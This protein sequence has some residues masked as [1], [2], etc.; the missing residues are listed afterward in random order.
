MATLPD[1]PPQETEALLLEELRRRGLSEAEITQA[2]RKRKRRKGL[3]F[4]AV[5]SR[6]MVDHDINR[7]LNKPA[8][9]AGDLVTVEAAAHRLQLHPKTVLRF[10]HEGRLPA[11]RIGKAYRIQRHDLDAFAGV[12]PRAIAAQPAAQ[13]T[14]IVDLPNIGAELARLWA[15]SVTTALNAPNDGPPIRADVV[16]EPD[17]EHLKI[18]IVGGPR[19]VAGLLSLVEIW[20]DQLPARAGRQ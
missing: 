14:T 15:Q 13:V 11:H 9:P 2:L 3:E 7:P 10:I 12:S 5:Q 19:D 6:R 8:R 20:A 17:R 1:P 4:S 16:Y 18:V